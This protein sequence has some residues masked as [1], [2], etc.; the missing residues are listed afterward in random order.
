M[1]I[2][3]KLLLSSLVALQVIGPSWVL[4]IQ[5]SQ[6]FVQG[7]SKSQALIAG[8]RGVV[9]VT[10][11]NNSPGYAPKYRSAYWRCD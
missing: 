1:M 4:A 7:V 8:I 2:L 6:A 9:T 11:G 3:Y 5:T 10:P